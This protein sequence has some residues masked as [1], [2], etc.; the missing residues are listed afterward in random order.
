MS[1]KKLGAGDWAYHVREGVGGRIKKVWSPNEFVM[2]NGG[3]LD[4]E[5]VEFEDGNVLLSRSSEG[6]P[7]VLPMEER[8]VLFLNQ[9][10]A[11]LAHSVKEAAVLG[12]AMKLTFPAVRRVLT[13]AVGNQLRAL[14]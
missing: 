7:M 9:M 13:I 1:E 12:K 2:E 10:Q 5:C 14:G 6:D 3:T 4:A 8:E 11:L